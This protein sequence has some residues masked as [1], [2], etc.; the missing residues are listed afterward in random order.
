MKDVKQVFLDC[1]DWCFPVLSAAE[2]A[3]RWDRPSV[4]AEY[5]VS[6]LVGH[7]AR[8]PTV[9]LEYLAAPEPRDVEPI[10][11]GTYYTRVLPTDDITHPSQAAIRQRGVDFAAGGHAAVV[12]RWVADRSR[13]EKALREQRPGRLVQVV[14][15]LPMDL[16]GY[17]V[18]RLIETLVHTDDLALSVGLESPTPPA[19]AAD[20]AIALLVETARQRHGDLA[21][22]RALTRRERDEVAALRVL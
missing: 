21:A 11:P 9:T 15:G 1:L 4:L 13:A 12:E 17:L 3:A 8:Q 6:G 18:T 20:L 14:N 19:D 22:L 10:L 16:D 5:S 7:L 2:V